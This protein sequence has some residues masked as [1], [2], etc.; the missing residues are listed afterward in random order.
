MDAANFTMQN[1]YIQRLRAQLLKEH[2]HQN[3]PL[4]HPSTHTNPRHPP[5]PHAHSFH[6]CILLILKCKNKSGA[7]KLCDYITQCS[8][9]VSIFTLSQYFHTT[10]VLSHNVS[11]FTLRQYCYVSIFT[12]RQYFHTT[13][14]LSHYV[15]TAT[16]VLSHY[17]SAFTLLHHDSLCIL[18][19]QA[20]TSTRKPSTKNSKT[21]MLHLQAQFLV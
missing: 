11:T 10:S 20:R 18:N 1:I 13:S 3:A 6:S 16:S 9:Y 12:L 5:P 19:S 7:S 8:R 4:P 14:V 15:S 17:V 2:I 21:C